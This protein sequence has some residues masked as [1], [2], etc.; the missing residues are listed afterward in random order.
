MATVILVHGWGCDARL[1]DAVLARLDSALDITT[2]DFGYF[3]AALPAPSFKEPIIA[4]G[5]SL[6]ALWW[7]TQDGIPW[8]R[9]LC[10]DGFPRFTAADG[11][12]GVAPRMLERMRKRF[13]ADPAAVLA[14]FHARCG[15]PGPSS[16]PDCA[17]LADGLA[18]LAERD[19]RAML[20]ARRDD[21]WALAG[22]A[23]P[24][25]PPAMRAAAFTALPA[26]HVECLDAPGHAL[27]FT[28]PGRCAQWIERL[29]S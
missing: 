20:A 29:A 8:R 26:G 1:W 11:Y 3:G 28:Q 14:D 2:I 10:I 18:Q 4:V 25:V 27:P 13:A 16:A 9:L 23:D 12:P 5:H 15:I 21:V 17:R 24:I 7:L 6:G 19:G 22:N